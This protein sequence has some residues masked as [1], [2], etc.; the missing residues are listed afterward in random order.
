MPYED[1]LK[2]IFA[3]FVLVIVFAL[4][5]NSGIVVLAQAFSSS[6]GPVIQE[7]VNT[8]NPGLDKQVNEFYGC[9]SRI[10]HEPQEPGKAQVDNCYYQILGGSTNSSV[11]TSPLNESSSRVINSKKGNEN[12]GQIVIE[13]V[14]SNILQQF[15]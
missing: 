13:R 12:S 3:M 14:H 5:T 2:L 10:T 1:M 6:T 8:G 7:A 4:V 15:R 9:I 11:I